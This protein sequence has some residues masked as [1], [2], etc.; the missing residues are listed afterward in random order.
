MANTQQF[1]EKQSGWRRYLLSTLSLYL[2]L[3]S[4]VVADQVNIAVASNF[5]TT[6]RQLARSFEEQSGHTLRISSASTGK[7]YAQISHGAPFDLFLSADKTRPARL[8]QEGRAVASSQATYALG[9]LVFWSPKN[10]ANDDAIALLKSTAIK[11]IAI[12][13]PKTAPYGLAAQSVLNKLGLWQ[14]SKIKRVRGENIS[15]T[16]Q[17]VFSGAVDGGFVALSQTHTGQQEGLVWR[18]P[19]DYYAPIKQGLVLLNRAAKNRA[20]LSFL[21]FIL[22]DDGQKIIQQSGYAIEGAG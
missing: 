11:R 13:N 18:V 15:Q 22:S 14:H 9:Q 4:E 6:L 7:L 12:A 8:V 16:F 5:I 1:T 2:L 20:A 21:T 19:T 10:R 17:F 3:S